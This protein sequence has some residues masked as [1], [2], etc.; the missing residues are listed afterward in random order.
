MQKLLTDSFS[1]S[2]D[3]ILTILSD[4]HLIAN[5]NWLRGTEKEGYDSL[6]R[7]KLEIKQQ[8]KSEEQLSQNFM[9]VNNMKHAGITLS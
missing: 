5:K 2:E 3:K 1:I 6:K 7:L 9:F 8:K 4:L